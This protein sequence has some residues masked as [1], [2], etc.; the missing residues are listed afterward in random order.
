LGISHLQRTGETGKAVASSL[1][2]IFLRDY[3]SSCAF[4]KLYSQVPGGKS[5]KLPLPFTLGCPQAVSCWLPL[6]QNVWHPS[7]FNTVV[8]A[9]ELSLVVTKGG[10]KEGR[11]PCL[12]LMPAV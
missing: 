2:P 12:V 10:R 11:I 5:E 3:S 7:V 4:H 1:Y 8:L 9:L 6:L